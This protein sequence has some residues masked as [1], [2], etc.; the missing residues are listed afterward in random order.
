MSEFF[1]NARFLFLL[2]RLIAF[3]TNNVLVGLCNALIW[4]AAH[5]AGVFLCFL[6]FDSVAIIGTISVPKCLIFDF[7]YQ[8]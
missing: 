7:L 1:Y 8:F 4:T 6:H 2:T 5:W 3:G